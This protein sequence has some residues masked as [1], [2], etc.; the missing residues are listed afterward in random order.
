VPELPDVEG[1]RETLARHARGRRI[2]RVEVADSGVL[3]NTTPQGLGRA[4]KGRRFSDPSRWGKWLLAVTEE[5]GPTV[6]LH[7]GMTGGLVWRAKDGGDGR[8][9][10]DRVVFVL[11]GGELTFRDQRKLQGLWL[12]RHPA[13][14]DRIIGG[15]GPDAL[16][17]PGE[18]LARRLAGR[19][20]ALKAALMDQ[21]IVAGLGNLLSDEILWRAGLHPFHPAGGLSGSELGRL[22]RAMTR[23]LRES[24]RA[25]LVPPRRSWL[26]GVRDADD[27]R[28]P[29]CRAELRHRRVGGRRA[30]WCP[31]C[32]PD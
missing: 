14:V 17:L 28:C 25:G 18:E 7:F 16:G 6:L 23:V 20:G 12:A 26:T 11:D 4:L 10:H 22:H 2:E 32:Q 19:R 8:H 5:G 13:D 9:R 15:Q 27:P 30:V 29:R 21:K 3:R 31:Q 24:V 1:F